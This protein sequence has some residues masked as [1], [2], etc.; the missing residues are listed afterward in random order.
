[1]SQSL[2]NY[3][4]NTF[5]GLVTDCVEQGGSDIHLTTNQ[6]PLMRL[7]GEL[8]PI[9]SVLITS[10]D[11]EK[12]ARAMLNES[13]WE[14]FITDGQVDFGYTVKSGHR[15]RGNIYRSMGEACIALRYLSNDF[16]SFDQLGLPE[17]VRTLSKLK[18]G[19]VLVTGATGSGKSTTLAAIINHINDTQNRHIITIEDPVE[20]VYKSYF[21]FPDY[22]FLLTNHLPKL[23]QKINLL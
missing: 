19:L 14:N 2:D 13:Q 3:I 1:M 6:V 9:N 17:Y 18:D 15:F 8:K 12:I 10:T 22:N 16:L 21:M 23:S 20:F 5:D 11:I 4:V 7:H